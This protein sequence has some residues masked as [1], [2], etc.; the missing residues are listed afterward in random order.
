MCRI[1]PMVDKFLGQLVEHPRHSVALYVIGEFTGYG[2]A[3]PEWSE[4]YSYLCTVIK[5]LDLAG[6]LEAVEK[7]WI[8]KDLL[9]ELLVADI[10]VT[11]LNEIVDTLTVPQKVLLGKLLKSIKRELEKSME[12]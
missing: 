1:D 7:Q 2:T 4:K 12:D 10:D 11:T 3:K 5:A 9:L 8:P 6:V